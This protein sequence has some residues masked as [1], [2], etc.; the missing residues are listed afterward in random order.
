MVK[1]IFISFFLHIILIASFLLKKEEK[2]SYPQKEILYIE[3]KEIQGGEKISENLP[4]EPQVIEKLEEPKKIRKK[5]LKKEKEEKT[6][7]LKGGGKAK[8]KMNI[9]YSYYFSVLLQKIGENWSYTYLGKDTL[10][11]TIYFVI[12]KDGTIK[13]VKIEKSSQ[14]SLFDGSALRAVV[15]TKRVPP[16]PEE[17]NMEF[18]QVHLEFEVP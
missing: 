11:T 13:D 16:L 3:L 5:E 8:L 10:R 18:L 9:P 2:I 12:L 14:N 7:A 1:E 4:P 6:F 15:L 17:M